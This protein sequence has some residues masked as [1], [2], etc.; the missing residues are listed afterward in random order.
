[1][2]IQHKNI[3]MYDAKFKSIH[4]GT[5]AVSRVKTDTYKTFLMV[6]VS[7]CI[8]NRICIRVH[9]YIDIYDRNH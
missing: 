8:Y 5:N 4:T 9:A 7:T 1:M 6:H 3:S 2:Y